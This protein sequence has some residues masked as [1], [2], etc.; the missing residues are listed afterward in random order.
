MISHKPLTLIL[1]SLLF[2]GCSQPGQVTQLSGYAQGTTWHVSLWTEGGGNPEQLQQGIEE[3]F[4]RL[5]QVLSNYRP[6]S[7]IERFNRSR[8][9]EAQQ[10]GSEIVSL[11]RIAGD[12]ST[13]T[14]GCY[15]LT[16]K[17][18]FD[19][20]GFRD[21]QLSPP[22]AEQLAEVRSQVG[23]H[24]IES[25]PPEQ[26]QK[27][28]PRLQVD[29]SS[30][31]QGYSVARIALLVEQAGFENYIVEIGGEM[32]V[33]G[34]KPDGS[35]WR[36]GVERPVPGERM[37]AKALTITDDAPLAVMT[38]GTYRHYYDEQG[39][40]YSH[41]LDARS[42]KPISHDT[43][44]VTVLHDDPTI[45]DGW[46]TAL[47]CLGSKEGLSAAEAAGIA[48]LFIDDEQGELREISSPAWQ[49]LKRVNME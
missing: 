30:I 11:V 12:V 36:I 41:V 3:E 40:R 28:L 19:L 35:H 46:S 21:K 4:D 13:A 43:V 1:L 38:S 37:V 2:I 44:S 48:V 14:H 49:S 47:L 42:G 27:K 39:Q 6:D 9:T 16:I 32:L 8:S 20:W 25:L 10:V 34:H 26:L 22:T 15:D 7:V 24:H 33:R 23:F 29:V 17:P 45:A 31:A 18:L 5:D